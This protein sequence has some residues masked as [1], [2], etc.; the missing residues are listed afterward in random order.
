MIKWANLTFLELI[1][2]INKRNYRI[3]SM[4]KN[5]IQKLSANFHNTVGS[6]PFFLEEKRCI[7][8][9]EI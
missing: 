8:T 1:Q 6:R 4:I 5:I 7:T 3:R 9:F 2:Q